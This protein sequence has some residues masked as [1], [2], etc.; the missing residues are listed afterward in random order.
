M[1]ISGSGAIIAMEDIPVHYL[2]ILSYHIQFG[3]GY[4]VLVPH[5]LQAM[6]DC[7]TPFFEEVF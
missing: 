5:H 1:H 7:F 6:I 2:Y 3:V 4:V